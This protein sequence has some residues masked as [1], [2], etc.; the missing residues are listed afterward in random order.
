MIVNKT[1]VEAFEENYRN[2]KGFHRRARQ[3]L[4]E[5]Q[6]SSVV[7]NVAAVALEGYLVALCDLHGA[8]PRNHNYVCLMETI[9]KFIDFPPILNQEIRSLD[10]IFG[11]CS[12]E[13]YYHGT[14]ASDD[15]DRVL[16]MCNEV[17]KLFD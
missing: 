7:F 14:P 11:I 6:S 15:V 3:F 1:D 13:N 2:A 10:L 12:L 17:Q 9:E 4:S 8:E 16:S 5:G